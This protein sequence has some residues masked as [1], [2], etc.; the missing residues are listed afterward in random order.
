MIYPIFLFVNFTGM[1]ELNVFTVTAAIADPVRL[2]IMM[3]LM[4][5][6]ASV[7]QIMH[8]LD[9]LQSN[10]SNHLVILKK[11]GL[12]KSTPMGRQKI[13]ELAN[14]QAA[15]LIE[16]LV[17][18]QPIT[19]KKEQEIKP[20]QFARTCYDHLAGK[21]GVAIFDALMQQKAIQYPAGAGIEDRQFFSAEIELGADAD[22]IFGKLN[23]DLQLLN[24]TRRRFAFGCRDWTERTPH[25]AGALGAALCH[26]FFENKW[27]ARKDTTRS[28]VLTTSGKQELKGLIG[29]ELA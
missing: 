29:L 13:Y 21:L 26:S 20:I 7:T 3:Y 2:T 10:I 25:L 11:A 1:E 28:I 16:L 12:I 18:M 19:P 17:S 6:P 4:H 24:D 15:Q 5:S 14:P 22:D 8:H 27:I 9:A 23:V